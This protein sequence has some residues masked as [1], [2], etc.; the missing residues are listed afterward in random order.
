MQKW[1]ERPAQI[2]RS[3]W[4]WLARPAYQSLPVERRLE[5]QV[6]KIVEL[7]S[8]EVSRPQQIMPQTRLRY[9]SGGRMRDAKRS[10][11]LPSRCCRVSYCLE[12][13]RPR[14]ATGEA[15]CPC[16]VRSMKNSPAG[17]EPAGGAAV[18]PSARVVHGVAWRDPI[19]L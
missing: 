4:R 1:V 19:C 2:L 7:S 9:V 13:I 6:R 14:R 16:F 18:N 5:N 12:L 8:Q 15:N 10:P 11:G 3:L 17:F